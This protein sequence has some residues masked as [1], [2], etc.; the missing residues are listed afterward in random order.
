MMEKNTKNSTKSKSN[1][2]ELQDTI[3]FALIENDIGKVINLIRKLITSKDVIES[4]LTNLKNIIKFIQQNLSGLTI[5]GWMDG[6]TFIE[7]VFVNKGVEIGG[8]VL[9]GPNTIIGKDCKIGGFCELSNVVLTQNVSLGK[10]CKLN[11]CVVDDVSLPEK[12]QA[13]ECIIT[14]NKSGNLEIINF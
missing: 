4:N 13:K 14:K 10:L 1:D 6:I 5:D 8:T 3:K 11:Y 12:F 7:P 9:L 2:K